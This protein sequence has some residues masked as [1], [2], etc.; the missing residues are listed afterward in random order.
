[1]TGSRRRKQAGFND[2]TPTGANGGSYIA[3]E[4][5]PGAPVDPTPTPVPVEVTFA[6]VLPGDNISLDLDGAGLKDFGPAF[7]VGP[8]S[9]PGKWAIRVAAGNLVS[10]RDDLVQVTHPTEAPAYKKGGDYWEN[11]HA[12][13]H[14]LFTEF[15]E[16]LAYESEDDFM[17]AIANHPN[18]NDEEIELASRHYST[19]VREAALRNP[20]CEFITATRIREEALRE[21]GDLH[22]RR[23]QEGINPMT[24]YYDRSIETHTALAVTAAEVCDRLL[25]EWYADGV[26][27][28]PIP[29]S[30]SKRD[31]NLY[32]MRR[33]DTTS[34][35]LEFAFKFPGDPTLAQ[36]VAGHPNATT[37]QV[38][39]A[40]NVRDITVYDAAIGNPN[41]L[42]GTLMK[43]A[44]NADEEATRLRDEAIEL[45]KATV[46]IS[47]DDKHAVARLRDASQEF[48]A[49]GNYARGALESSVRRRG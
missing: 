9:A 35:A 16:V 11:V 49:R 8:A 47:E 36:I 42:D 22:V 20:N 3:Q 13:S 38:D 37:E 7:S 24:S 40:C 18:A 29:S 6:D 28:A 23:A 1:M 2:I 41:T 48:E 19:T 39:R 33:D 26:H 21:V 45:L 5:Q 15:N 17:Y 32:A 4:F 12:V 14:Q 31:E 25:D 34:Q 44:K 43:I 30:L 27:G 46:V 10:D